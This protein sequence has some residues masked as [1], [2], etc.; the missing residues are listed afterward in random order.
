MMEYL[1]EVR[2]TKSI[3]VPEHAWKRLPS[4][5]RSLC[6]NLGKTSPGTS[7]L[8]DGTDAPIGKLSR[9]PTLHGPSM[10]ARTAKQQAA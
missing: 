9:I 6:T 5:G 2:T 1:Y 10:L 8:A 7:P 3:A 4:L